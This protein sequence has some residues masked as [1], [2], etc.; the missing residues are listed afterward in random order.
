MQAVLWEEDFQRERHDR[1]QATGRI[2]DERA[3][4]HIQN[5]QVQDDLQAR[6][7]QLESENK[8]LQDEISVFQGEMKGYQQV[9]T[10][11]NAMQQQLVQHKDKMANMEQL[12]HAQQREYKAQLDQS[13][14][15]QRT[16][17]EDVHRR[18]RQANQQLDQAVTDNEKLNDDVLA[19]TQQVKQYKKQV[20]G[21]KAELT[22]YKSQRPA[23]KEEVSCV[24]ACGLTGQRKEVYVRCELRMYLSSRSKGYMY[25]YIL[26]AYSCVGG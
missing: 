20:D 21:L 13:N 26:L 15:L 17:L 16:Q 9:M 12:F 1:E 14:Q 23:T 18:L 10:N 11:F 8:R 19:K 22:K 6:I 2:E 3:Q 24:C 4:L 7:H 25:I 5:Q